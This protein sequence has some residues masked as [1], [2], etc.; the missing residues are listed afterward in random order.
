[1]DEWAVIALTSEERHDPHRSSSFDLTDRHVIVPAG[2]MHE[3]KKLA[4]EFSLAYEAGRLDERTGIDA[5][6]SVTPATAY[7]DT[8][9]GWAA[10]GTATDVN[11]GASSGD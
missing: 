11:Y 2:N 8:A 1:M 6:I 10:I 9:N 3:A 7:I 5:D 4:Y